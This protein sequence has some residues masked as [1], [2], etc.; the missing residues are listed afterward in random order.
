MLLNSGP[1]ATASCPRLNF[2]MTNIFS[3]SNYTAT[4]F[5][6]VTKAAYVCSFFLGSKSIL[7]ALSSVATPL[8][9]NKF[10]SKAVHDL[11]HVLFLQ[12]T[13]SIAIFGLWTIKLGKYVDIYFIVS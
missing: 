13:S 3:G 5:G 6:Y 4:R 12:Y 10:F 11:C 1:I 8:Y 2:F 7:A 9:E